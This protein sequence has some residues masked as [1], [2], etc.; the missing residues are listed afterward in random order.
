MRAREGGEE[1]KFE[2]KGRRKRVRIGKKEVRE[3]RREEEN[4]GN[5]NNNQYFLSTDN[6]LRLHEVLKMQSLLS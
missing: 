5:S 1:G 6:F 4:I 3:G 2:W